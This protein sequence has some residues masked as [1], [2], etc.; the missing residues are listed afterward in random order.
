MQILVEL[1]LNECHYMFVYYNCE[2]C[3]WAESHYMFVYY[4]CE[5]C[6]W[7]ECHYVCVL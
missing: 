6:D 7:A 4:N 1:C 2:W 5:W 3:D